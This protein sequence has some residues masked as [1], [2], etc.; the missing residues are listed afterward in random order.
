MNCPGQA[1]GLSLQF[2]S[3][4]VAPGHNNIFESKGGREWGK[5]IPGPLPL[6]G[7][8]LLILDLHPLDPLQQLLQTKDQTR[9]GQVDQE[10]QP[11]GDGQPPE[12]IR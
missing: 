8:S 9:E 3:M 1:R 2:S 4:V 12:R 10:G 5:A 11:T 7:S 6:A